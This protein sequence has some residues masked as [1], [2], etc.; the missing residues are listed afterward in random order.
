MTKFKGF[1]ISESTCQVRNFTC[2]GCP[3]VCRITEVGLSGESSFYYGSRCGRFDERLK[4]GTELAQDLYEVEEGFYRYLWGNE[5]YLA[6][7]PANAVFTVLEGLALTA[8]T[9]GPTPHL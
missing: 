2:Q 9:T 1:A 8:T 6:S 3:N 5:I 7:G 4:E